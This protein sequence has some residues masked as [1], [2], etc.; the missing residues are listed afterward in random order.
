MKEGLKKT[1]KIALAIIVPTIIVLIFLG[2]L[3][4]Y[5]RHKKKK[6][7]KL[8][9]DKKDTTSLKT[10]DKDTKISTESVPLKKEEPIKIEKIE[11]KSGVAK[12]KEDQAEPKEKKN[13]DVSKVID[14]VKDE[15][16]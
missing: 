7:E 14:D 10:I 8:E 6:A 9:L 15:K 1:G 12:T 4:L 2:C 13:D 16:D 3:W 5:K 11:R